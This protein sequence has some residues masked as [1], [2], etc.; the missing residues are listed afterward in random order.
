MPH[1]NRCTRKYGSFV[2]CLLRIRNPVLNRS[3]VG[4]GVVWSFKE[5]LTNSIVFHDFYL[6]SLDFND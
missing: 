2:K 4:I 3:V 1:Y 6:V 5:Q